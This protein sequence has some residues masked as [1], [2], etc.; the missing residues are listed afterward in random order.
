MHSA[1]RSAG[2]ARSSRSDGGRS[3][4]RWDVGRSWRWPGV[5]TAPWRELRMAAG[6]DARAHVTTDVGRRRGFHEDEAMQRTVLR[7]A[8]ADRARCGEQGR[9]VSSRRPAVVSAEAPDQRSR[10]LRRA[11]A[12][13]WAGAR[14]H[15]RGCVQPSGPVGRRGRVRHPGAPTATMLRPSGTGEARPV[16]LVHGFAARL[17]AGSP[18]GGHCVPTDGWSRRSTTGH[19]RRRS[20]IWATD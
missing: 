5:R 7:R 12:W 19:G 13:R 17:P 9:S 15:R 4:G 14:R 1:F 20:R 11:A 3:L 8:Q 2:R 16:V 18:S 10:L 6:G